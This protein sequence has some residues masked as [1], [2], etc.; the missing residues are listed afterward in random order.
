MQNSRVIDEISKN[1][2]RLLSFVAKGDLEATVVLI[3]ESS[4]ASAIHTWHS[5]SDSASDLKRRDFKE[6]VIVED[7]NDKITEKRP[8]AVASSISNPAQNRGIPQCFTTESSCAS[9]TNNCSG[10]GD[11]INKYG[12]NSKT[13]CF[14]C[15]CKPTVRDTKSKVLPQEIVEWG[16]AMCQKEDI[17]A[18]FW[19]LTGFTI[20]IIGAVSFALGLLF[21][22][23]QEKLPGVIGAG[24]SRS[25]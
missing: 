14:V 1:L 19:L 17:S 8:V 3:P 4:R 20:T 10:H 18:Q 11:C 2:D 24:V 16:G 5:T 7:A 15:S 22:M 25:K 21:N 12:N 9:Q 23:G 13:I 6:H